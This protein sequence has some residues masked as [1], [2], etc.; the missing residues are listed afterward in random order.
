M[1]MLELGAP[2]GIIP[3]LAEL[4][5]IHSFVETGTLFGGTAKLAA[6]YFE[7]VYTIEKA[8]GLYRKYSPGLREA[9]NIEPLLGDSKVMLPHVIELLEGS[10]AV[11]WLDGHWSGGETAGVED[12]C[13]V[14]S[15]IAALEGRHDDIVLIDNARLFLSAPPAPHDPAQWPSMMEI[16]NLLNRRS[17]PPYVQVIDD[18]IFI[19]PARERLKTCL[20]EYGRLRSAALWKAFEKGRPRRTLKNVVEKLVR[21]PHRKVPRRH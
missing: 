14:L 13:P 6:H 4:C 9:G 17:T 18:V 12:E 11:F 21:R 3:E 8:D 16:A 2:F 15:E 20:I 10:P 19:V 1:G 5:D 7:K